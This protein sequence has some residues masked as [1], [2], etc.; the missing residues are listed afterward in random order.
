[1]RRGTMKTRFLIFLTL[2]FI[3]ANAF[4]FETILFPSEDGLTI[5][6]DLYSPHPDD[7]PFII[8]FHRAG[9]S[10]GEYREIAPRL[11]RL[12]F[13]ALAVD[14]RSGKTVRGIRNITAEKAIAQGK[15]ATYVDAF[16][17]MKAALFHTDRNLANS[18]LLIWG[19]SY[20]ASLSIVL[21][22]RYPERIAGVIAF[23]PG[24]YFSR[25]GKPADFIAQSAKSVRCPVFIT[26]SAAE[27]NR[28]WNIYNAMTLKKSYFLPEAGGVHGSEALWQSTP[29]HAEYWQAV[30]A[31]LRSFRV[32][33]N[34][35]RQY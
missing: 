31:F 32:T 23:A 8:L 17:D 16:Q 9:W 6:A 10:R 12:G 34:G 4:S 1:M 13:N 29:E 22:A 19:S 3:P 18:R 35:Q 26:S 15:R 11:N 5:T 27:K 33:E 21:A 2:L 30:Q 24:E 25:L 7:S 20:S 28:W 14:L